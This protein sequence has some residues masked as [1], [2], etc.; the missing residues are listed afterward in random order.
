[1]LD[2]GDSYE[3]GMCGEHSRKKINTFFVDEISPVLKLCSIPGD[4]LQIYASR[5][6]GLD[7]DVLGGSQVQK[8]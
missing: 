5:V 6:Y 7:G 4:N 2:I 8:I 1:M 3:W